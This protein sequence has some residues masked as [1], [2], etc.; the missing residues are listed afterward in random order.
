ML[1]VVAVIVL[2][3]FMIRQ[4]RSA[5]GLKPYDVKADGFTYRML[6]YEGS[7]A[8]RLSD[9]TA[10][11]R[12]GNTVAGG[13]KLTALQLVDDCAS[14][15]KGWKQAF[16]AELAGRDTP[17]CAHDNG[18]VSVMSARGEHYLVTV[19]FKS[20]QDDSVYPRLKQIFES[21]RISQ[22]RQSR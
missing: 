16:K 13:V 5:A 3:V 10:A 20:V 8:V 14:V 9:N 7:V 17:V 11:L 18:F 12:K 21:V 6:F 22:A 4:D 19:S 2:A 15:G 1:V